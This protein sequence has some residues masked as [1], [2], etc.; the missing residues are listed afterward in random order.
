MKV[1]KFVQK[2]LLFKPANALEVA[3]QF[4]NEVQVLECH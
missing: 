2:N 1:S 3:F 4:S